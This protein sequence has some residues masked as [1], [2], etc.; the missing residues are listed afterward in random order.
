MPLTMCMVETRVCLNLFATNTRPFSQVRHINFSLQSLQL[1]L[2]CCLVLLT[3][4]WWQIAPSSVVDARNLKQTMNTLAHTPSLISITLHAF[5]IFVSLFEHIKILGRYYNIPKIQGKCRNMPMACTD[6]FWGGVNIH[7]RVYVK[8]RCRNNTERYYVIER[9][10][11]NTHPSIPINAVRVNIPT[12]LW[13]WIITYEKILIS[14]VTLS[15]KS[16]T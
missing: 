16:F 15:L 9:V 10:L 2:F 12:F 4:G 11:R 8:R 13:P 6:I 14:L 7:Q 5:I 3:S 1:R